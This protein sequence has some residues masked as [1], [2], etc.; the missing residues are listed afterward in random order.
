MFCNYGFSKPT[1]NLMITTPRNSL[2]LVLR[3]SCFFVFTGRAWQH[4]FWDAPF[5]TLLWDEALMEPVVK[6]FLGISWFEYSTSGLVDMMIQWGVRG[7]GFFY[8]FMAILTLLLHKPNRW[9]GVLYGLAAVCL[10][11]LAFLYCKEKFYHAGQFFEYA[12]QVMSPLLFYYLL[13]TQKNITIKFSL[14]LRFVVALTFAAHGLYA[15][16]YYPQPGVFVDMVINVLGVNEANARLFL[17][18]AGIMDFVVAVGMF[19]P[20]LTMPSL[21]YC[22]FWGFFTALARTWANLDF[23]P[24]AFGLLHQ[25]LPQT[26]YRLPHAL[27]PLAGLLVHRMV[28]DRFRTGTLKR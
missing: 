18:V 23:G 11:F 15:F 21:I 2:L 20:G 14:I 10:S 9:A 24:L 25:Y 12:V 19:V 5:R 13:D 16:G 28:Y 8:L 22:I 6:L 27:L 3:L 1:S 4:L 7:F 26:I 17:K